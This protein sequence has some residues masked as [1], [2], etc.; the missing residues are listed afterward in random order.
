MYDPA[1][2]AWTTMTN[3]LSVARDGHTATLLANGWVLIVG[4]YGDGLADSTEVY[5]SDIGSWSPA[6]VMPG[7]TTA[8]ATA[9]LLPN[10]KILV[11]EINAQ[12]Y[13]AKDN[14]WTVAEA[15]GYGPS[16]GH[17]A[18]LLPNGKVLVAGGYR[19][20][21]YLSGA[22]LYDWVSGT[23]TNTGSLTTARFQYTATLLRNGKVLATGGG[24]HGFPPA[25]IAAAEIYDSG[26]GMWKPTAPMGSPRRSHVATLLADGRVLVTGGFSNRPESAEVYDSATGGWTP[27]GNMTTARNR[28]SATLLPDGKVLVAAGYNGGA[29]SSAELYD[30][31]TGQW[32]PTGSLKAGHVHHTATLLPNGKVLVVGTRNGVNVAELYDPARGTWME[33]SPLITAREFHAA[34]L[35]PNGKVLIAGGVTDTGFLSDAELY[36]PG[37]G[38]PA[39]W[40]PQISAVNSPLSLGSSL[41]VNGSGFRGVS[42]GSGGNTQD[43]PGD[44]PVVQLRSVGS[45]QTVFL[46]STNWSNNSFTSLPVTGFPPGY[47]LATVFVNGIPSTGSVVNISVPIPTAT[48]LTDAKRLS[49]GSFQFSFTNSPGAVFGALATTSIA[50]PLSN[51]MV[52]GGVTEI[53]PGRFQFTDSAATNRA[54]QFYGI[55]AP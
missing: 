46:L 13:D 28:H 31:V 12:L 4:A 17:T 3:E 8:Y 42:G 16:S 54:L 32:T 34:E 49:D 30:P 50:L 53:S 33:T 6:G 1:I 39:S 18:T 15:M 10:G 9:T 52:L 5:D 43:S 14:T 55:R 21:T 26:A 36:D 35:L 25:E 44:H 23:W 47:A 24:N 37:L 29:L 48:T 40:R 22:E 38:F 45:G 11:V 51:W 41:V 7:G 20:S 2:G 19:N 27:T